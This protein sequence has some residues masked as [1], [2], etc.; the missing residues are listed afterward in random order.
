MPRADYWGPGGWE[1]TVTPQGA[2]N[3]GWDGGRSHGGKLWTYFK[4]GSDRIC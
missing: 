2:D 1:A 3:G 4:D